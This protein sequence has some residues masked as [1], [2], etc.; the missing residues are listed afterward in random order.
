MRK[1]N[2]MSGRNNGYHLGYETARVHQ[3][4][5]R[6]LR[7]QDRRTLRA[8]QGQGPRDGRA[9][10]RWAWETLRAATRGDG[11]GGGLE[12]DRRAAGGVRS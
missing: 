4:E 5:M 7:A 11:H 1:G 8:R 10:G 6:A 9:V 12:C 2:T 3:A